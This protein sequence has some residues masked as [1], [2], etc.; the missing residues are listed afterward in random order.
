MPTAVLPQLKLSFDAVYYYVSDME[1]AIA[2]YRDTL[3]L[4]LLSRDF[5]AR[6]NIDGVLF[7]VV[8]S[9]HQRPISGAGNARLC[10]KVDDI[11]ETARQLRER[12]ISTSEIKAEPGGLLTFFHDP[13]GNELCVWQYEDRGRLNS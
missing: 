4:P 3:G 7:E 8:P 1:R 13:D 6:F 12:G 9:P 10:F 5:V 2:F 11:T